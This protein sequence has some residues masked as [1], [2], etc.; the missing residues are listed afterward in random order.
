MKLKAGAVSKKARGLIHDSWQSQANLSFFLALLVVTGFLLPSMG[1]AK[2]DL[3][4]YSD[5]VF[6]VMLVS[7]VA[8]AWGRPKLLLLAAFISAVA[9]VVRWLT[10]WKE[11]PGSNSGATPGHYWRLRS[12]L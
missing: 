6:S 5:I 2:H 7:G 4:R 1:F 8:I 12:S 9:L 10:L 11:T 3:R